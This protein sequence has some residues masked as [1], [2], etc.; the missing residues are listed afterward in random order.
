MRPF[1]DALAESGFRE[2]RRTSKLMEFQRGSGQT[3][4]AL[5][6]N[7]EFSFVVE[8]MHD[9]K[10]K[11]FA[12]RRQLKANSGF[13]HNIHMIRFSKRMNKGQKPTHFGSK[14]EFQT[15]GQLAGFVT[16]VLT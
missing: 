1:L 10:V 15:S 2:T 14:I 7:E 4:Y 16:E 6:Q 5:R 11:L 9:A 3:V 13:Y 8:P 12:D